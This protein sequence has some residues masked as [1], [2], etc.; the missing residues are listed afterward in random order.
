MLQNGKNLM[1]CMW[2]KASPPIS[3]R[4]HVCCT[5]QSESFLLKFQ[6]IQQLMVRYTHGL[7]PPTPPLLVPATL[8]SWF[9]TWSVL[10]NSSKK[11]SLF[12]FRTFC[13]LQL[14]EL[15]HRPMR[16]EIDQFRHNMSCMFCS[17]FLEFFVHVIFNTVL[18]L[19][20]LWF[21]CNFSKFYSDIVLDIDILNLIVIYTVNHRKVNNVR[22]IQY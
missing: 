16:S 3:K 19:S 8:G 7:P 13:T 9:L 21:L 6:V 14:H 11:S 18:K 4:S 1:D 17:D 10:K 5:R 15:Q 2:L 12:L 22:L 20:I